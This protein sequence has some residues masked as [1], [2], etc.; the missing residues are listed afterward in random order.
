MQTKALL[1]GLSSNSWH[2]NSS[3]SLMVRRVTLN[4][5]GRGADNPRSVP[6]GIPR[7]AKRIAIFASTIVAVSLVWWLVAQQTDLNGV[8]NDKYLP[9]TNNRASTSPTAAKTEEPE[10]VPHYAFSRFGLWV[11]ASDGPVRPVQGNPTDT[12]SP[13]PEVQ[14]ANASPYSS[15]HLDQNGAGEKEELPA[16]QNA[17]VRPLSD[18]SARSANQRERH[19]ERS[20]KKI[21]DRKAKPSEESRLASVEGWVKAFF[22]QS[23]ERIRETWSR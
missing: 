14:T 6:P 2:D 16:Q 17:H 18:K 19:Q 1:T 13:S 21:Y 11:P 15:P 3:Q 5:I 10:P 7:I 4:P 9:F 22:H 12:P 20:R 8:P 23:V